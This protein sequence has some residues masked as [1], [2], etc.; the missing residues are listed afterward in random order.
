MPIVRTMH[1][2]LD[3]A[4][5]SWMSLGRIRKMVQRLSS[6]VFLPFLAFLASCSH[7]E[8]KEVSGPWDQKSAADYLDQRET[9]WMT[10]QGSARDHET[11]CVSCHTALPYALS[12]P[13]LR[14]SVGEETLSAPEKS[15]LENVKKRVQL[16]KEVGP[17]YSDQGY[18]HKTGESRGTEAVLNALILASYDAQNGRLSADA[19]TA[20]DNMWALQWT[21]GDRKGAWPWLQ[22][23][24]EPWEANDSIYYGATL[25]AVAVGLAPASYRSL[26]EIQNNLIML[27]QYLD[28]EY[29]VQSTIN[30][31]SLLWASTK[32]PGILDA[33]RARA[34]VRDVLKKQQADGGWRLAPLVWSEGNWSLPLLVERWIRE[35]GTPQETKSDGYATAM[36]TLALEGS[37]ISHEEVQLKRARSW[38][39]LNQNKTEGFW[40]AS[41]V[42]KR[43]NASSGIG[44]FMTDAAT[45]YAV[46][47]LLN[48]QTTLNQT[49]PGR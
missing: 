34:I 42:N 47:A 12:R 3:P 41:S 49:A 10:W 21:S 31:V 45:A 11:F 2:R 39:I 20:F 17:Y 9:S 27:R 30:R 37:G 23:D 26:P 1:H 36:I 19:Q 38:L 40:S 8:I 32:W 43:R 22:F 35:D 15:L 5:P 48:P 25:A 4:S 14:K 33:Q 6:L 18:D 29:S 7:S 44:R 28:R 24:L 46:L 13:A 16:W